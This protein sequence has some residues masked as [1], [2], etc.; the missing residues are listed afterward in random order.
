VRRAARL[1]LITD[2]RWS[3]ARIAEVAERAAGAV[4]G[5]AVQLR[6]RSARSDAE[7]VPFALRLREITFRH[8]ALLVVNRRFGLARRVGADGVHAPVPQVATKTATETATETAWRSAPAHSD[9]DVQRARDAGLDAV[10]VSPIFDVPG[11]ASARGLAA[12]R[13][14]C[15]LAPGLQIIALGG[16]DA[17]NASACFGAGAAGVAVIRALLDADDPTEAARALAGRAA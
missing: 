6:D 10:L 1:T 13:S 8:G 14:A 16:V 17:S 7:L 11:K 9:E 12:L 3:E 5:F 15:V 2:P 4:P